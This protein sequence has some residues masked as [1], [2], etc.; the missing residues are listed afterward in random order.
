MKAFYFSRQDKRLNYGDN[1]KIRTGVTHKVEGE[2]VLC[3]N[4]LHASV[5]LLDAL[6]YAPDSY[7]WLVELSGEI[8]QG[9]DKCCATERTYLDGFN[10]EELLREFAKKCPLINIEK[11]EPYCSKEDYQLVLKWLK[12]GD[13]TL[14]EYVRSIAYSVA[15]SAVC[16]A[17]RSAAYSAASSAGDSAEYAASL[18]AAYAARSAAYSAVRAADYETADSA[19]ASNDLNQM[20]LEM[21]LEKRPDWRGE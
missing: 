17:A 18:A 9:D 6:Q 14:K 5:N 12:T 16:F 4:G 7:L 11:I 1:R 2:P 20:L 15:Y 19:A 21:I 3:E 10:A 13:E 8:V